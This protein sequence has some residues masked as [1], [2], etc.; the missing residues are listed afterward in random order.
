M[1]THEVAPEDLADRT[2][3]EPSLR[4]PPRLVEIAGIE[5]IEAA[6]GRVVTYD[7]N[8]NTNYN[9]DVEAAAPR[10]AARAVARLLGD[11][12]RG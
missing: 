7:V 12:D 1:D 4:R 9:A 11:L 10:S 5:Y 3:F 8:T 6:D 2:G